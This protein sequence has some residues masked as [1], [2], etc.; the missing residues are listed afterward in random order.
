[1][2]DATFG[3][4]FFKFRACLHGSD[5]RGRRDYRIFTLHE[6]DDRALGSTDIQTGVVGNVS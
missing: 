3:T 2:S 5:E 1:M 6:N 4:R